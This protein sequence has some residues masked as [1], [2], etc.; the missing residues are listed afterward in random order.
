M[1]ALRL[2]FDRCLGKRNSKI[3]RDRDLNVQR[4]RRGV[5]GGV[6]MFVYRGSIIILSRSLS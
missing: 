1:I 2:N 6:R 3:E 4:G 5:R